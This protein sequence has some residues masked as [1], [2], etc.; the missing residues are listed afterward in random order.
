MMRLVGAVMA[1]LVALPVAAVEK[2][3]LDRFMKA[4]VAFNEL[5]EGAKGL[6]RPAEQMRAEAD[7][8]LGEMEASGGDEA[9]E[10][11]IVMVETLVEGGHMGSPEVV[12][13]REAYGRAYMA[14]LVPCSPPAG[15]D[16][17]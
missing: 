1:A 17:G 11:L 10:G 4:T 12:A 6:N 15:A 9:V 14:A 5:T 7:C 8:I 16:D 13:F 3:T 2:G